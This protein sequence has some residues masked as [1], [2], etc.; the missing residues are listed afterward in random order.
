MIFFNEE[1]RM[2]NEELGHPEGTFFILHSSFFIY[3]ILLSERF[4]IT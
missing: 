1:L 3:H 4:C 2:K